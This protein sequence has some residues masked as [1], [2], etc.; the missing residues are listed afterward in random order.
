MID[1]PLRSGHIAIVGFGPNTQ[2]PEAVWAD[3][4][5]E[6]WTLNHGHTLGRGRWDR[7][8]EFHDTATIDLESRTFTR[9]VSQNDVLRNETARPIYMRETRPDVPCSVRFDI[10][11][12]RGYFGHHCE[13]LQ[14]RPYCVMAVGFMIGEVIIRLMEQAIEDPEL[15]VYGVELIDDEEWEHQ[16]AC[17]EFLLGWAMGRG[18]TV[19]V[20]DASAVFASNGL[21]EYDTGETTA[22]L[23]WQL[24][25]LTERLEKAK[26]HFL[27]AKRANEEAISKMQTFSGQ[28]QELED[29]RRILQRLLRGGRYE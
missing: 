7:L 22:L 3:P 20:P 11:R 9:G 19:H 14:R 27:A 5:I 12:W 10:D 23:N 25:H 1:P 2:P 6:K 26:E 29:E 15:A 13:K 18:I 24:T 16:R 21:Y 8:F 28:I 17:C 4:T